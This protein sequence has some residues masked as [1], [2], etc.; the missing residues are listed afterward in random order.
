MPRPRSRT[1]APIELPVSPM[2]MSED[3]YQQ[4]GAASRAGR[5]P[6]ASLA[7]SWARPVPL[8][9]RLTARLLGYFSLITQSV[10]KCDC[11]LMKCW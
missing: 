9:R 3:G 6:P 2:T 4:G 1:F 7:T 8:M 5:T 11:V 10:L